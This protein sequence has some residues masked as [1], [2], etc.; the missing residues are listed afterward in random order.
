MKF[1]VDLVNMPQSDMTL[2]IIELFL[3]AR[4]LPDYG[5]SGEKKCEM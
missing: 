1:Y 4:V 3:Q 5:N 2:S